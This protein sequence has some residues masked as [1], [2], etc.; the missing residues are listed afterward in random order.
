MKTQDD[1][2]FASDIHHGDKKSDCMEALAQSS[3][4]CFFVSD[5]NKRQSVVSVRRDEKNGKHYSSERNGYDRR[6]IV[7][8]SKF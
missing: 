5:K 8:N 7:V 4:N 2:D 6:D 3:A 1:D